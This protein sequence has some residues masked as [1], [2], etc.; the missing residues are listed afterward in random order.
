MMF[1]FTDFSSSLVVLRT[2]LSICLPRFSTFH[3][4]ICISIVR[5][6]R[7]VLNIEFIHLHSFFSANKAPQETRKMCL[8]WRTFLRRRN[9]T[10][11]VEEYRIISPHQGQ[12][13]RSHVSIPTDIWRSIKFS[14]R[15]VMHFLQNVNIFRRN[16]KERNRSFSH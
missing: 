8:H 12:F 10:Y 6:G 11:F 9:L 3:A 4:Y 15:N 14:I 2:V 5:A 1:F 7:T 16:I 13:Q